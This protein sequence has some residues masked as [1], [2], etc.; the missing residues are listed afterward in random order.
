MGALVLGACGGDGDEPAQDLSLRVSDFSVAVPNLSPTGFFI[1]EIDASASNGGQLTFELVSESVPGALSIGANDGQILV[2]RGSLFDHEQNEVINATVEV[3]TGDVVSAASISIVIDELTDFQQRT[4]EYF[5]EVALG[6]E[7]GGASQITRKWR[8]PLRAFVMGA[9]TEENTNELEL[10]LGEL[11]ELI[12][13]GFEI[14]IVDSREQSNFVMFFG[15]GQAYAN[16]FPEASAFITNS[17]GLFFVSWDSENYLK[18]GHM[19]VDTQR[20]T[21]ELQRHIVRE[22]LTQS[23]GLARDSELYE[24][25]IFQQR[26]STVTE[27]AEIDRELIR[28]LY[29]PDMT[30]GLNATEVEEVL[31]GILLGD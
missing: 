24:N 16:L 23:L 8:E 4:I 1:G 28:L 7:I 9:P 27:Y 17:T 14:E 18:E 15:S 30:S 25:S 5:K 20:T 3:S 10:I 26:V 11:E 6:F 21:S 2:A 22:E 19:F 29:H 31:R 12:T 13:D